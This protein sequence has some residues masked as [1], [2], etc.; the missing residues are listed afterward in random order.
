MINRHSI[1]FKLNI[2]FLFTLLSISII[3]FAV[4][5]FMSKKHHI[6]LG[7]S[8]KGLER[9]LSLY[10]QNKQ[11]VDFQH[12]LSSFRLEMVSENKEAI[13]LN[14]KELK[15]DHFKERMRPPF[16][17][18]KHDGFRPPPHFE[19]PFHKLKILEYKSKIYIQLKND[20][21]NYLLRYSDKESKQ[22]LIFIKISYLLFM[23]LLILL[24]IM[25]RKNL[26]GLNVLH[27]S[28]VEYENG[29]VDT[30][31]II[32]GKDEVSLLSKQFYKVTLKLDALNKTRKLF[33]RNMMHELKTP[34]TKSK[35]YL[36][37][38]EES[39][40]RDSLEV[41]LLKL[42]LLIDDMA[43]IE[44]ISTDNV[45]IEKKEYR[46]I[47]II[48]N[49]MDMLFLSKKSVHFMDELKCNVKV[50]FKLF[51]IVLKNLIDNGIKYSSDSL[52]SI[53]CNEKKIY[54]ASSGKKLKF[55]FQEYLEPFFKGDLNEINQRGFGLGLYIVNEILIKHGFTFSYEF[56]ENK[57]VFII[58]YSSLTLS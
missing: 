50:D 14:A 41:S 32:D 33:L 47:D 43:N 6:D 17:K 5:D 4:H 26:K 12:Y 29:I 28:L 51:S 38:I 1:L 39:Q 11:E 21:Y 31:K 10:S 49:A 48:E 18:G 40:M 22:I 57:N 53:E 54:V 35:L 36:S 56:K 15:K 30:T 9:T 45:E 58:D 8:L 20:K 27:K 7:F 23:T 16:F 42:E 25:I 19:R 34:L 55:D 2:I 52:V 44:K 13:L 46:L 37:L 24:Y 3:F